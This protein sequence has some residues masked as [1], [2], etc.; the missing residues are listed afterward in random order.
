MKCY[1]PKYGIAY[2]RYY[3]IKRE[4]IYLSYHNNNL[5]FVMRLLNLLQRYYSNVW[6]DRYSISLSENWDKQLL[7]ARD[8]TSHA[9]VVLSN[10]YLKTHYCRFEFDELVARDIPIIAIVIDELITDHLAG[11]E[12]HYWIDCRTY[13]DE[14]VL[15][16]HIETILENLPEPEERINQAERTHYLYTLIT[17]LEIELS[18]LPTSRAAAISHDENLKTP[19]TIRQRGYDHQL[20]TQW[21][22][23]HK[24][25]DSTLEVESIMSWFEAQPQFVLCGPS[26][27][28]KTVIAQLLAL[29]GAHQA[30]QET[31]VALPIW[32]DLTL[33][34]KDQSVEEFIDSQW[35]LAF[36]WKHWLD[37]NQAFV[38]FDNWSDFC[39]L[40]PENINELIGWIEIAHNHKIIVITQDATDAELNLPILNLDTVP[41]TQIPRYTGVFLQGRQKDIFKRLVTDHASKVRFSTLDFISCGI[42]LVAM[43]SQ[44]AVESWHINPISS[45]I[46]LRWKD[47]SEANPPAF[48]LDYF[49]ATLQTLAWNM[50]QKEQYRFI[51]Y[52][53]AHQLLLGEA[54]IQVAL[55]LGLLIQV[56][57]QL[58]FESSIFQWHLA[59]QHLASDGIYKH[60]S[61][62][63]FLKNGNRQTSKWDN[64]VVALVDHV[65]EDQQ[66][67]IIE[68]IAEIDPY[69]AY[70]CLQQYSD[71][72]KAYLQPIIA[73]LIEVRGKNPT[74]Q[75][76]LSS[77]LRHIPY[78]EDT[79][80]TLMQ[81][82]PNLDWGSQKSLWYDL[83][84]LPLDIPTDFVTRVERVDR[85]FPDSAFDLLSDS[86][87]LQYVAYLAH[88]I[89]DEDVKIQRNA[90]WLSGELEPVAMKVGLFELL[91]DPSSKIRQAVFSALANVKDDASLIQQVLIWLRSNLDWSGEVGLAIYKMGRP[92]SG[93]LLILTHDSELVVDDELRNA[94]MKYSEEDITIAVAQFIVTDPEMRAVLKKIA[95]DKESVMRVQKLLQSSL[96]QLPLDGLNR[97]KVDF[98]R[99][100]HLQ[101]ED[102]T[103]EPDNNDSL[104]RRTQS[105]ILIANKFDEVESTLPAIPEA[106][107]KNLNSQDQLQRQEAVEQLSKFDAEQAIPLLIQ[108]ID[109]AEIKV[110]V[111]ALHGLALLSQHEVARHALIATL[112]HENHVVTDTATDLLKSLNSLDAGELLHLLGS[113]IVQ[114]LTAV[115]DIMGHTRY[116]DAVQYLVLCLDDGRKSWMSEKTVGDYA[117]EALIAIGTP[118]A[119]EAV[120][121]S[122]FVQSPTQNTVVEVVSTQAASKSI[123]EDHTP[124]EEMML[125]LNA[126]RSSNWETAQEAARDL[127]DFV[128]AH[129]GTDDVTLISPLC[130]ALFDP[131]EHVRLA[132]AEALAWLQ[133]PSAIPYLADH[134]GDP[135]WTVQAAVIRTLSK[136][137]AT[138]YAPGIALYLNHENHVVREAAAEAL[139]NLRNPAVL[140]MLDKLLQS[141][142]EFL[143]LAAIQSIYQIDSDDMVDYLIKALHDDDVH[144]RWFAMKHL[145]ENA[146]P[147]DTLEV[148][149]LLPDTDKPPWEDTPIGDYATQTLIAINTPKS[150]AILE[151]W[152]TLKKRKQV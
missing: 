102:D 27:N 79:A 115:I 97:L 92:V 121:K 47:Y 3:V 20:L 74:S 14:Q 82:M 138:Q 78:V 36:Y 9:I 143:R 35:P 13:N 11:I 26:G 137:Q 98:N 72:Y 99:V 136:L 23:T 89:H 100:L 124:L 51:S 130:Q 122:S 120:N 75:T 43:N 106:I 90:I 150:T 134:L 91:E 29:Q 114:T 12:P 105:A 42:E 145:V 66:Q 50:L 41:I 30:L 152:S 31:T 5:I 149:R 87:S 80:I 25:R 144:V 93:G 83:L 123:T 85:N 147:D 32:L 142:D 16:A 71:L 39:L 54:P 21:Y 76:A 109:D 135:E 2:Q 128:K 101:P 107:Q 58:R 4:K 37:T 46:T 96:N 117:A 84:S 146:R 59:T 151:K 113:E 8:D 127:R 132:V 10:D 17:D 118:E 68:Q 63:R 129:Q 77:I 116:Q 131:N 22:F 33:W 95:G 139:G 86:P 81:Q 15:K 94:I 52:S 57:D 40:H 125:S 141:E 45:I 70:T 53:Q 64:V 24:N 1:N 7:S 19:P 103:A 108:A 18:L 55:D 28:G 67:R 104:Y 112:S 62:P 56:G 111:A 126:I 73:K 88:M 44:V 110:Q 148:A 34:K 69:L 61:Q 133:H 60:L 49:I 6:L 38:I 119:L 48:S 65:E 140:P